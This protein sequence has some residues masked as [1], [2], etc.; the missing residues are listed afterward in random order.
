MRALPNLAAVALVLLLAAC[1]TKGELVL[2]PGPPPKPVLD[3]WLSPTP[4]PPAAP[5]AKDS[6]PDGAADKQ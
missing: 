2:P 4:P 5:A 3:Q 6:K 1:G